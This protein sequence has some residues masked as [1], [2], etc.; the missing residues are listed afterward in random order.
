MPSGRSRATKP[1]FCWPPGHLWVIPPVRGK[2]LTASSDVLGCSR[3][4]HVGS[5][6]PKQEAKA[7]FTRLLGAALQVEASWCSNPSG[8]Q[9]G[10]GLEPI[11]NFGTEKFVNAHKGE[12]GLQGSTLQANDNNAVG[13]VMYERGQHLQ[14]D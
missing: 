13:R 8:L 6:W 7:A 11:G 3:W 12:L 10:D 2:D 4:A 9:V 1:D 14:S 5:F